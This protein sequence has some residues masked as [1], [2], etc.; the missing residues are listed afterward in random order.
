M[1]LIRI[2]SYNVCYTKLLRVA[3]VRGSPEIRDAEPVVWILVGLSAAP[4]VAL[5]GRCAGRLGVITS[6]SIHYTKLYDDH[7]ARSDRA[8]GA[9]RIAQLRLPAPVA[10]LGAQ[11]LGARQHGGAQGTR[12]A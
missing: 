10:S 5:W 4:S 7:R 2:T 1:L 9:L 6:Y 8:L 12:A 3:I 11:Q